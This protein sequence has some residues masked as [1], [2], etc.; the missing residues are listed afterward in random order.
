M[1]IL[2]PGKNDIME[3]LGGGQRFGMDLS[4]VFQEELRGMPFALDLARAGP[5]MPRWRSRCLTR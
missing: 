5:A 4:Y 2:G 1:I 3:Y